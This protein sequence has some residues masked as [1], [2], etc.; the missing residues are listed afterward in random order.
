MK[1]LTILLA[2]P[3]VFVGVF[4]SFH[5]SF[6]STPAISFSSD[7]HYGSRGEM[8]SNLQIFLSQ[9][10]I[11]NSSPT[12]GYYALTQA[13][14]RRFQVREGI[15]P[16]SGYFGP[17]TRAAANLAV[18]KRSL[19]LLQAQGTSTTTATTTVTVPPPAATTSASLSPV[20]ISPQALVGLDCFLRNKKTGAIVTYGKGSGV[21]IDSRGY[22]LTA[23]HVVD[24]AF[25]NR[26]YENTGFSTGTYAFDHCDAGLMPKATNLPTPELIRKVNP[27]AAL[28]PLSYHASVLYIPDEQGLSGAEIPELDFAILKIDGVSTQGKA[29]GVTSTPS[30]FVTATLL[31]ATVPPTGAE[32]LTYGFPGYITDAYHASFDTLYLV[33]SVG[34]VKGVLNGDQQFAGK[35]LFLN[36]IMENSPGRSGSPLF[37]NGYVV[38]V[39]VGQS[40]TNTADSYSVSAQPISAYLAKDNVLQ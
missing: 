11:Y 13:A 6:A 31:P 4:L 19:A 24:F 20:M 28:G 21:V 5:A 2:V 26:F 7:L 25:V 18:L 9:E 1:K 16:T 32:V 15:S 30:T 3:F 37:W 27:Y 10:G 39:V 34:T 35:P 33:G 8:V 14:V 22:V 38:G 17:K 36:T 23:R 29:A 40:A 12:G